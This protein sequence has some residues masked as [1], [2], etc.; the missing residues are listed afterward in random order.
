LLV[1]NRRSAFIGRPFDS[2]TQLQNSLHRWYDA[3]VGRWISEDPIGFAA[4]DGNLYRYVGNRTTDRSDPLGLFAWFSDVSLAGWN[5]IKD[6]HRTLWSIVITYQLQPMGYDVAAELLR[7]SLQD[8]PADLHIPSTHFISKKI[9]TSAEYQSFKKQIIDGL[10]PCKTVAKSVWIEFKEGDLFAAFHYGEMRYKA[11]K[12]CSGKVE[13][14]ALIKDRYDFDPE[15]RG[16]YRGY[17]MKW[18]AVVA[19]NMAWT[20][21]LFGVI[22]NYNIEVE[23]E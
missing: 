3:T 5:P 6:L 10:E 2:D 18:L 16:Y 13:F 4:G 9:A 22:Q 8:N 7:W 11:C 19:N 17:G 23:V 15:L 1:S 20:D 12:D 21:Q 14:H